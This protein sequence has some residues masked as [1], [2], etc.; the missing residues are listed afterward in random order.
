MKPAAGRQGGWAAGVAVILIASACQAGIRDGGTAR[1]GAELTVEGAYA[2][3]PPASGEVA[4]YFTVHNP[5]EAPDT[6]V[7]VNTPEA[8]GVMYHRNVVEGGL[9][10]MEHLETLAV[11]GR[12]SLVLAPGGLH[13]MLTSVKPRSPG[14]TLHLALNF[15]HAGNRMVTVV[16]REP[17]M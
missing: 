4:V 7:H 12:D 16:I 11:G 1:P 9:V 13:L 3:A 8:A 15:A 10:R 2:Y 5:A 14:D 17:G 6:L